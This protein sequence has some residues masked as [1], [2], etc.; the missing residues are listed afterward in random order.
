LLDGNKKETVLQN[1]C[2]GAET[3]RDSPLKSL[4]PGRDTMRPPS[5]K[6]VT[7]KG[8]RNCPLERNGDEKRLAS[9]EFMAG[10]RKRQ[11]R[12]LKSLRQDRDE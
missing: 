11:T 10:Q 3:R 9:K 12:P 6:P 7:K 4:G 1:V 2:G 5:R 8:R